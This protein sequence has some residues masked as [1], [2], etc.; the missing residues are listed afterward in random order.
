MV[1][2]SVCGR[3]TWSLKPQ[4]MSVPYAR[5][6]AASLA[7]VLNPTYGGPGVRFGI[8]VPE[9]TSLL[10]RSDCSQGPQVVG[11]LTAQPEVQE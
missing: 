9:V 2:I 8:G 1:H 5:A 11:N 6:T 7:E 3:Y 4:A 10:P